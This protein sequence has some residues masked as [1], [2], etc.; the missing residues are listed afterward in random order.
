MGTRRY[1]AACRSEIDLIYEN[2]EFGIVHAIG[3][4][5]LDQPEL[6]QPVFHQFIDEREDVTGPGATALA[7]IDQHTRNQMLPQTK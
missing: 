2:A 4:G 1:C 7:M 6:I 5:L 3:I